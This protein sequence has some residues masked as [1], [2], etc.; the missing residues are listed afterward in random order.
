M[1]I[2]LQVDHHATGNRTLKQ[3]AKGELTWKDC[4]PSSGLFCNPLPGVFYRQVALHI[5]ELSLQGH[6]VHYTDATTD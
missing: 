4:L 5:A 3:R 1:D 6:T 2:E